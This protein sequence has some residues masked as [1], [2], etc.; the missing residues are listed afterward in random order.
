MKELKIGK[1]GSLEAWKGVMSS[2]VQVCGKRKDRKV[3]CA[4]EVE[5]PL[6]MKGNTSLAFE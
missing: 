4:K 3:C 2:C 6:G 1:A 5:E